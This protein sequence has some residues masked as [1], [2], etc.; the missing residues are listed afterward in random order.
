[1]ARILHFP[2]NSLRM[3][4]TLSISIANIH[5]LPV[6]VLTIASFALGMFW[7]SPVLFGKAWAAENNPTKAPRKLKAPFIFGGTAVMHLVA[8]ATLGA[9]VSGQGMS[10]GLGVGIAISVLLV[11]P[12]MAGT[13]L[14]ADRS[15]KLLLIDVGMYTVLYSLCGLTLGVW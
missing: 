11:F 9:I 8:I 10:V 3:V 5:W 12:A 15:N 14:F 2:T 4:M 6:A 13:Y 1:M 7:H